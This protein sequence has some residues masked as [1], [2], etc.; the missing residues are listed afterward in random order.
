MLVYQA[1]SGSGTGSGAASA[2]PTLDGNSMSSLTQAQRLVCRRSAP[3]VRALALQYKP[4][5]R[6]RG[7]APM[8]APSALRTDANASPAYTPYNCMSVRRNR[9]NYGAIVLTTA[10]AAAYDSVF[11]VQ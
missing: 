3:H 5:S 4:V 6:H 10:A 2:P 9:A 11:E 7:I 1:G 8:S